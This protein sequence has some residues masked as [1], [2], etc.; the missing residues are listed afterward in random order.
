MRLI[1]APVPIIDVAIRVDKSTATVRF[2]IAPVAI[3]DATVSPYL[4]AASMALVRFCVPLAIELRAISHRHHLFLLF[5][6]A[7]LVV[8]ILIFSILEDG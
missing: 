8:F 4:F 3:I 1:I 5:L 7:R 6:D 2:V